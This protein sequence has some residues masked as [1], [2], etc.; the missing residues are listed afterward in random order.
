MP[1][2]RLLNKFYRMINKMRRLVDK[3]SGGYEEWED[4]HFEHYIYEREDS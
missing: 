2:E 3:Y 1:F 4:M